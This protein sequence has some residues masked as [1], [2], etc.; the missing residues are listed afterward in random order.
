[1]KIAVSASGNT[2]ESELDARFGRA[3][4]FLVVDPETLSY[5]VVENTQNLSAAQGAG[6]QAGK[7][8][9]DC[10]AKVVIT[11]NCGPKAFAVLQKAGI[12]VITGASGPIKEV[13]A[14]YKSGVL[15][16]S[17]GPSVSGHWM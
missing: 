16:P 14:Q 13:L 7:T 3:A 10:G 4:C 15:S 5:E 12:S 1:M 9:A 17:N 2:L 8:V 11:G 6:I